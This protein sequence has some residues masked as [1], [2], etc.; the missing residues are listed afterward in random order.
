MDDADLVRQVLQHN[1]G[2]YGELITRYTAQVAALIRAQHIPFQ[3]VED[4]VQDTFCRGLDRLADMHEP[5]KFGSWLY[6]IARN[7]CRDWLKVPENGRQVGEWPQPLEL[8]QPSRPAP[9]ED[10]HPS[11]AEELKAC[12]SKL[13]VKLREI[14]ELY[15]GAIRVTYQELADRLGTTYA[16]VNKRLTLARKRL[17]TCLERR[18]SLREAG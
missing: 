3:A 10:G 16:T 14:I 5:A 17:R 2:A 8:E 18:D 9:E 1:K 6:A 12:V 7:L 11:R 15:Y 13:P 4:L